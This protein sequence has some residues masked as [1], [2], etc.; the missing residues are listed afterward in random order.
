MDCRRGDVAAARRIYLARIDAY[1]KQGPALNAIVAINPRRASR[2]RARRRAQDARRARAAARHSGAGQGQLRDDG[3]ADRGRVDCAGG[4]PSAIATR[5]GAA[6][7]RRGRGHSRPRPTCT[8]W[9]LES[10]PSARDSARR[11]IRTISIAILV[12]RAAERARRW[13]RISPSRAW[14]ATRADRSAIPPRTTISSGCAAR[15]G[16]R[17]GSGSCRSRARRTSAGRSRGASTDLAIDARRHGR[18]RS[19]RRG[20][21][22][23][24]RRGSRQSYR[25]VPAAGA[26]KGA[27]IGVVRE[28]LRHGARG[29]GSHRRSSTRRSRR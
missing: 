17:A 3:D 4:I 24:P 25:D 27:R 29:S 18:R 1:D 9:P 6:A 2:R 26:L 11:A 5:S 13:R 21:A 20:D 12:D 10:P 7:A 16:C 19:G 23:A 14:A 8:S 22:R 15:R 28:S